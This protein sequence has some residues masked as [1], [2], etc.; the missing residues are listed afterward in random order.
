MSNVNLFTYIEQ[1][2]TKS[3]THEY[4]PKLAPPYLLTLGLSNCNSDLKT[5][6]AL[7]QFLFTLPPEIVYKYYMDAI[8][9]GKKFVKWPK[10]EKKEKTK[11]IEELMFQYNISKIEAT[12]LK[13]TFE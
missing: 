3:T 6:N 11:E 9:R 8:P 2:R 13:E 4:D 12:K 10:K 7:N 1:L 5:V